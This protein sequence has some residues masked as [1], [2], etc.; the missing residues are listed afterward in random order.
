MIVRLGS[1]VYDYV[2]CFVLYIVYLD[3]IRIRICYD[4]IYYFVKY[5]VYLDKT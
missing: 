4:Y 2:Y 5:I 3:M 1:N